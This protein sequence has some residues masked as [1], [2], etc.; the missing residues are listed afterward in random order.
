MHIPDGF[1]DSKTW[2]STAAISISGISYGLRHIRAQMSEQK[3][4]LMGVLA[5]FIFA[6][7][8]L[9]FP[10]I[11]GTSGHFLGAAL[12]A[13]F[14]GPWVASVLIATILLIQS[15]LFADG[16]I[17]ALGANILNMGLVA[18]FSAY[19]IYS[20]FK[21]LVPH[22][23]GVVVGAFLASWFS[24]VLASGACA[25]E[26]AAS[27]TSPLFLVLPAM[28]GWH[29]IIG[30]GEGL[31]T[32][33]VTQYVR[34]VRPDL[35]QLAPKPDYLILLAGV[36]FAL[37]L[38]AA[39]SPYASALPDGLERVAEDI[40][41]IKK[42]STVVETPLSNYAAPGISGGMTAAIAGVVG[43][44][45]SLGIMYGLAVLIKGRKQ[46]GKD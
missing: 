12:A 21:N 35:F 46:P 23:G 28:I 38:A 44:M 8:M 19:W 30:V 14:L 9:N 6:A 10:V 26:L 20:V 36:I 2:I 5:A 24:V 31:I 42:A 37:F 40:G 43:T 16:G 39:V 7:Q 27:G 11:G 22:R 1:L 34:K 3:I 41:F 17:T 29:S 15:L 4:P 45:I 32:V 18:T 33:G 13:I 25:L